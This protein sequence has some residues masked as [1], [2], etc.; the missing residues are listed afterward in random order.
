MILHNNYPNI[1]IKRV[2]RLDIQV[3]AFS[4][5]KDKKSRNLAEWNTAFLYQQFM[6]IQYNSP[7][8]KIQNILFEFKQPQFKLITG[9]D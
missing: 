6:I 1:V 5:K 2:F 4:A 7:L 3:F 8:L 9:F